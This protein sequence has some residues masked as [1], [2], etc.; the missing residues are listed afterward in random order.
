MAAIFNRLI[1]TVLGL[2]IFVCAMF[3]TGEAPKSL[4]MPDTKPGE[5]GQWVNPFIGT[6]GLPWEIGRASCRER[7]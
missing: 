4:D 1:S 7:V 3:S 6:G 2:L 5:Y